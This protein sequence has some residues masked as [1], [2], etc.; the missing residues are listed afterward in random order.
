MGSI[1]HNRHPFG[2]KSWSP[3]PWIPREVSLPSTTTPP[4]FRFQGQSLYLRKR[5]GRTSPGES[6]TKTETTFSRI[7]DD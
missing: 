4:S 3:F 7:G 5:H 2:G 6:K 1:G